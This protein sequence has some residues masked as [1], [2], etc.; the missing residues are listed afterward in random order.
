MSSTTITD[1]LSFTMSDENFGPSSSQ[2]SGKTFIAGDAAFFDQVNKVLGD[3]KLIRQSQPS[4]GTLVS[5]ATNSAGET[6][7]IVLQ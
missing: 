6:F 3:L 5:F 4:I 7:K 1:V 2:A